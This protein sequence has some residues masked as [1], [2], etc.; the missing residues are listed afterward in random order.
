MRPMHAQISGL[1]NTD[2]RTQSILLI[3][4][5]CYLAPALI[6]PTLALALALAL[7]LIVSAALA[8]ALALL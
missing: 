7:A 2:R 6:V 1:L 4:V 5:I 8:L 3:G